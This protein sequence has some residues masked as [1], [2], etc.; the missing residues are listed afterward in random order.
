MKRLLSVAVKLAMLSAIV[1]AADKQQMPITDDTLTDQVRVHLANDQDV[2]GLNIGVNVDKGTVTLSGK[3]RNDKQRS[4]A[5]KIAKKV[6][7][8]TGVVNKLVISPD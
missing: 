4:K 1:L 2:G 5:E 3:V 6:K 7:G 8:V